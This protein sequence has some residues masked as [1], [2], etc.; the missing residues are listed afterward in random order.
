MEMLPALKMFLMRCPKC[1]EGTCR[2]V[3]L[4]RKY[5]DLIDSISPDLLLPDTEL[6]ILQ[7]LHGEIRTMVA[8]EIASE[9]DCSGQMVGRRARNLSERSLVTREQTGPV[10]GYQLSGQ[11]KEAYFR[12]PRGDELDVGSDGTK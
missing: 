12:N 8:S 4:S 2:V 7:T 11:A 1:G 6:R 5:G 3:N 9:L 10:Y